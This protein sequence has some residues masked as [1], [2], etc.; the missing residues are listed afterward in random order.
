MIFN[1]KTGNG[2][3][4]SFKTK[5]FTIVTAV[6]LSGAAAVLPFAAMADATMDAL[7][8]QIAALQAQLAALSGSSSSSTM[9]VGAC[10]FTRSLMMGTKGNDVTCLQDYLK[11]TGHFSYSG[12][13]T[14]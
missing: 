9:T 8:A 14:G 6:T 5:L 2:S 7:Q 1:E 13:S 3:R 11:S 12:G 4:V 10:T